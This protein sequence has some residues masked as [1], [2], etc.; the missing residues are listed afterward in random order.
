MTDME[1]TED[2]QVV[3]YATEPLH[4]AVHYLENTCS[5]RRTPAIIEP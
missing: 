5:L 4:Q 1:D 3:G 2:M